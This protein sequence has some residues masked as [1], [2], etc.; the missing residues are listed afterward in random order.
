M[1]LRGSD[2]ALTAAQ[3]PTMNR[4]HLIR[5]ARPACSLPLVRL[6]L[7][8][9]LH[10][11]PRHCR[12]LHYHRRHPLLP[13]C[14]SCTT[15]QP[16]SCCHRA[17]LLT[18]RR[19]LP[20]GLAHRRLTL[21]SSQA[22]VRVPRGG[23]FCLVCLACSSL[24][25]ARGTHTC[26]ECFGADRSASIAHLAASSSGITATSVASFDPCARISIT[27]ASL[28]AA[29]RVRHAKTSYICAANATTTYSGYDGILHSG[30]WN[31]ARGITA[32]A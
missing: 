7:P 15:R 13:R 11:G 32:F 20:S 23:L 24:A 21:S 5:Q 3:T 26:V 4:N 16:C 12:R 10:R 31:T 2:L 14:R 19:A 18:S 30:T 8:P 6:Q 1:C 9:H 28:S 27:R 17:P 29:H 22:L 25:L